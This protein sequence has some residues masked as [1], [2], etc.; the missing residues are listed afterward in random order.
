V[1]IVLVASL[2]GFCVATAVAQA[3]ER[4]PGKLSGR[5]TASSPRGVFVDSLSLT[6]EGDGA[7]GPVTGKVTFRGVNC[8]AQDELLKGTWDGSELR[9]ESVHRP[10][11]NVQ[12][13]N[14]QCGTGNVVYILRRKP[15]ETTFE[16]EARPGEG[17]TGSTVSITAS[18]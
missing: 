14:S 4:L 17:A 3:V 9:F 1:R 5:W 7:P 12:R 2:M 10:N 11:V 15:G 6:F 16:G 8:G 18:P 13:M